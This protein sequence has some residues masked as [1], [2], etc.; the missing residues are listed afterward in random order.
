LQPTVFELSRGLKEVGLRQ[1]DRLLSASQAL[2][3]ISR[4]VVCWKCTRKV[5]MT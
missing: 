5:L 4:I 2:S 3:T 1:A